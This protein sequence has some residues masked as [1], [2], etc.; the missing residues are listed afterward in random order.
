MKIYIK[1]TL[2]KK[3]KLTDWFCEI[4]KWTKLT[5]DLKYTED[6]SFVDYLFCFILFFKWNKK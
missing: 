5:L 3:R 6:I 2:L 4:E 1:V